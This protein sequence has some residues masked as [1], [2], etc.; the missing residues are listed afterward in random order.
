MATIMEKKNN[1][2]TGIT[3]AHV[4]IE[5]IQTLGQKTDS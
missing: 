2:Q 5:Q 3:G 4:Q 1:A